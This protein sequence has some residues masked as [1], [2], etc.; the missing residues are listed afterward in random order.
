MRCSSGRRGED[1]RGGS[2]C[3]DGRVA[4]VGAASAPLVED[5]N[6][7][8]A[9]LQ[10]KYNAQHTVLSGLHSKQTHSSKQ[11]ATEGQAGLC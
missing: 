4:G 11:G 1:G 8:A 10:H 6:E 3:R 7:H 2:R 5:A 9:H